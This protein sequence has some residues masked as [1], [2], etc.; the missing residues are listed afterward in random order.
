ME[1]VYSIDDY[2]VDES[3]FKTSNTYENKYCH[4]AVRNTPMNGWNPS[5][6]VFPT[7]YTQVID[8]V[9]F[10]TS[11][12]LCIMVAGTGHD[13][14]NRHSCE[15]GFFIRTALMKDMV[16]DNDNTK[17]F[18]NA[19][20]GTVEL[21]PGICFAEA[22]YH[23]AQQDRYVSS[24]W[25]STVGIIGW[26]IGGG[27]GPFAP[28]SGLGVDNICQVSIVLANGSHVYANSTHNTD[29][30]WAIRGGGGST[31][32][33][34]TS[35]T[36]KTHKIPDGGL[37]FASVMWSGNMCNSS[38]ETLNTIIEKNQNWTQTLDSK[39]GGLTFIGPAYSAKSEDCY[40]TWYVYSQ[41]AILGNYTTEVNATFDDYTSAAAYDYA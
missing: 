40:A 32:G 11:H 20:D 41:Y 30:F 31:W 10:A 13:F 27:H 36:I 8:A 35:I 38:L 22:H 17:G 4:L 14:M 21:G 16:F 23:A 9:N 18:D 28:S 19:T 24:G 7:N 26:S 37:S 1:P 39:W 2:D 25:A 15:N 12:N 3:C 29:L 5:F 34:I 33:V 6:I